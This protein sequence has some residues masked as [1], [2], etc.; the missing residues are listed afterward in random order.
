MQTQSSTRT[1]VGL[2]TVKELDAKD[3]ATFASC[4]SSAIYLSQ[5][6]ADVKFAVKELARQ[7]RAPRMVDWQNL[8]IL[9]R[10][11]QGT[12]SLAHMTKIAE[13]VD[14]QDALPLHAFCD[15]DWAGDSGEIIFLAGTSSG[16]AELSALNE[17]A[18]SSV[19]AQNLAMNDFGLNTTNLV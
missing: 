18:K 1:E 17:C 3:K 8:K 7:I 11:L 13:D 15:R 14:V 19:F 6:R 4:V 5:D 9:A 10:Y 16:E 12:R 2:D